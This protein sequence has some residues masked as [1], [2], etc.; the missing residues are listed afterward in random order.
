MKPETKKTSPIPA[1]FGNDWK[2]VFKKAFS[3]PI[4]PRRQF[5][6]LMI[7]TC[8][9]FVIV[10]TFHAYF[11]YSLVSHDIFPY[12]SGST[13]TGPKINEKKLNAVLLRYETKAG[14]QQTALTLAPVVLDPSR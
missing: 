11:F 4:A 7:A 9:F 6:R 14:V 1:G 2:G 10:A 3:F 13:T 5:R 12:T 8:V